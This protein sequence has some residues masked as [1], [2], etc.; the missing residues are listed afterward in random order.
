MIILW[1]KR[2]EKDEPLPR[3]E[4]KEDFCQHDERM[5]KFRLSHL[6]IEPEKTPEGSPVNA[7]IPMWNVKIGDSARN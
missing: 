6:P 5:K 1:I 7:C 2:R 3:T 4:Q